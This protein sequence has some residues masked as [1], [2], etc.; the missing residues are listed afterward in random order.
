MRRILTAVLGLCCGLTVACDQ[1][2]M[3]GGLAARHD[4]ENR[5]RTVLK[6]WQVGPD[7]N[8]TDPQL[9][10]CQWARGVVLISNLTEL[11]KAQDAFEVWRGQKGYAYRPIQTFEVTGTSVVP[12]TDPPEVRVDVVIDGKPMAMLV[13]AEEHIRWAP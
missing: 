11:G 2:G 6:S 1:L 7:G 4:A 13:V 8:Q 12:D 9:A 3:V 5:V 10:I